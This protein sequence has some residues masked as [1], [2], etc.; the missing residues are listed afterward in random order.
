MTNEPEFEFD[1]SCFEDLAI[2]RFGQARLR[3]AAFAQWSS[4][5]ARSAHSIR[6]KGVYGKMTPEERKTKAWVKPGTKMPESHS[7]AVGKALKGKKQTPE[8]IKNRAASL[9]GKPKTLLHNQHVSEA[10]FK[11]WK[12]PEF[13]LRQLAGVLKSL[14]SRCSPSPPNYAEQKLAQ[15]IESVLPGR[16]VYV[17]DFS[18][19]IG[20]MNPDFVHTQGVKKVIELYGEP[21]HT[22]DDA[23]ARI[24]R[25]KAHGWSTLV[26]WCKEM[27][28]TK[29]IAE[30]KNKLMRF[31]N[32]D[33]VIVD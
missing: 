2:K 29:T 16:Y 8:A 32:H 22:K 33:K 25:F 13:R 30:L 5:E 17:G 14:S 1:P 23:P 18:M 24:D 26:I 4:E 15:I 7:K 11:L 27:Q 12:D 9:R 31:E 19:W 20:K 10:I 3:L 6:M 21:Y 28:N